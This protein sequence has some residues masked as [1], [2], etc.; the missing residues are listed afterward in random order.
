MT[1]TRWPLATVIEVHPGQDG[2]VRVVTIKTAKRVY[3][4]P[5]IKLVH[6]PLV[7]DHE[8]E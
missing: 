7:Q 8:K 5:V 6:V 2:K 3:T 4:R 1:P